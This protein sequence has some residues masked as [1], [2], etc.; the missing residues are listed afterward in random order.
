MPDGMDRADKIE[1]LEQ[2]EERERRERRKLARTDLYFLLTE[3]LH[4]KDAAKPWIRDRCEEV[5][6]APNGYLDLWAREHYK[7]TIITFA[8]TIQDILATHGEGVPEG[9]REST[10]GIFSHTRPIAKGFLRQIKA[11][12]ERN[13]ELIE[14][15]PD[16]LWKDT[17]QAPKW[18]EDDG[19]VVKRRSNPKEATIEAWG[20]VDGQPTSKHFSVMVFDDIVTKESVTTPEMIA[21]TTAALELSYNLGTQEG[22]RRFIG[23]RYH[24]NDSYKTVIDRGT[25]KARIYPA[26]EDGTVD[27]E[28]VLLTREQLAKKRRDQGPYTFACQMLQD[29]KADETQGFR[30]EWLRYYDNPPT[31][32]G[33]VYLLFDPASG[34]RKNNDYTSAWAVRLG[35]DRNYYVIDMVRDRLNLTQRAKLV[36]AWHRKYRPQQV[37]YEK[38]GMMADIEH[39]KTVQETENYRFD[40]EEVGGQVAKPDR[41]KRLIPLFEQ[42]HIYL[43]RSLHR[44]N[45]EGRTEDLVQTFIEQEYKAFPVAIHDDMLDALAR[46]AEPELELVWPEHSP[47]VASL[48]EYEVDY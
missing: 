34:K 35:Q 4:R 3:I 11:E 28:P 19:L 2:L 17:R 33:N 21:K 22:V 7:S 14:L 31:G 20:L 37:R 9:T 16:V 24:Y 47:D 15:F 10:V 27:G 5:Q 25:A 26:T 18:S 6:A 40:M 23:T 1:L 12:F 42:K 29:P 13:T 43:P 39:I 8:K 30:E 48:M 38:Y 36:I 32:D 41:I 46:I 44:T 45:Y